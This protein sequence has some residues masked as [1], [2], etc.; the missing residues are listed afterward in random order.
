MGQQQYDITLCETFLE[1]LIECFTECDVIL[2][3]RALDKL[4][5]LKSTGSCRLLESR[6]RSWRR[7]CSHGSRWWW[8]RSSWSRSVRAPTTEET[9]HP[10]THYMTNSRAYSHT[11]SS[12]SHLSHQSRLSRGSW[13]NSCRGGCNRSRGVSSRGRVSSSR[14]WGRSRCRRW[15]SSCSWWSPGGR[16][17]RSS[18]WHF[19]I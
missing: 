15:W 13:S 1:G 9:G 10:S 3:L 14:S 19:V 11:T 2:L 18:S 12:C 16:R 4:L 7:S 17:G 6:S 8:G 5:D